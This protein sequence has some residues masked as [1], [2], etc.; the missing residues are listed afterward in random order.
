MQA[1]HG[2]DV[3]AGARELQHIAAAEAEADRCLPFEIADLAL[4]AF[5]AQRIERAGDA[6]PAL[7][8]VGA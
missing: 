8:R 2:L 6:G 1:D 3:G 7:R 5:G 4:V